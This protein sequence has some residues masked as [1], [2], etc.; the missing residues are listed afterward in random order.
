MH[1]PTI[2]YAISL[3]LSD[4]KSQWRE[5]TYA[6]YQENLGQFTSWCLSQ[7]PQIKNLEDLLY[8][9]IPLYLDFLRR[10]GRADTTIRHR[11]RSIKTFLLWCLDDE[12]CETSVMNERHIKKIKMPKVNEVE[13]RPFSK[14]EV[15]RLIL[16]AKSNSDMVRAK[17]DHALLLT[18]LDTGMRASEIC[19]EPE[20]VSEHTGLRIGDLDFRDPKDPYIR[21]EEGKGGKPRLVG[22]GSATMR[23]LKLYQNRYRETTRHD[24]FFLSRGG[25]PLT[26]RGLSFVVASIGKA[27]GVENAHP[28]RFRHTFAVQWLKEYKD[29]FGLSKLLGH[30]TVRVT[31]DKYLKYADLTEIRKRGSVVD[32]L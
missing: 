10:Q 8:K 23:A 17:R 4:R 9:H 27:A 22:V 28:H 20:R 21:V 29:I 6:W 5:R 31:Q 19:M 16:A 11:A 32:N 25:E 15:A 30:S 14:D 1:Q 26:T 13:V 12:E 7:N 2:T 24:Y 18:L 3:F